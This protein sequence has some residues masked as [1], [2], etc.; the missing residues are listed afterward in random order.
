[1]DFPKSIRNF[2]RPLDQLL[3]RVVIF[4]MCCAVFVEVSNLVS[5][6]GDRGDHLEDRDEVI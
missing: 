1:M 5:G 2:K 3:K 4:I 6:G